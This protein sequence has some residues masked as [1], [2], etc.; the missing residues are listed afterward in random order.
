L[1]VLQYVKKALGSQ[2]D[3]LASQHPKT[4]SG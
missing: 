3:D 4:Y 2:D 1:F